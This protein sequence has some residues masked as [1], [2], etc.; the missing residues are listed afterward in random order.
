[1][2]IFEKLYG[3]GI[4]LH[5]DYIFLGAGY[6]DI[7]AV[8]LREMIFLM[9]FVSFDMI[10][11]AYLIGNMTA[12]IVKG[13]KTERFRDKMT[14]LIK[15]MNRN[16]LDKDIRSQIKDHLTH[17]YENSCTDASV[18]DDIPVA[19]RSEVILLL[20]K[21]CTSFHIICMPIILSHA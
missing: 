9:I 7:H 6:G 15:Y 17:E 11:G 4:V 19:L 18:L 8:N 20:H 2:V 21:D 3:I 16:K 12:L 5:S 10:L 14:D 1:M 13:S